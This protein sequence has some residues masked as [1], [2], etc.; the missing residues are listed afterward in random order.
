MNTQQQNESPPESPDLETITLDEEINDEIV[1]I[2]N[3]KSKV[4][5]AIATEKIRT[6]PIGIFFIVGNEFCE[7]LN[8]FSS[9]FHMINQCILCKDFLFMG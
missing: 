7:R 9:I 3:S 1:E 2:K 5:P 8:L 6:W 4:L